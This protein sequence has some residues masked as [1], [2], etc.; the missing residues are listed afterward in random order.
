VTKE[1]SMKAVHRSD[2]PDGA[3]YRPLR[4]EKSLTA[5]VTGAFAAGVLSVLGFLLVVDRARIEDD[6][7][8]ALKMATA[9]D[10]A[11]AVM[12]TQLSAISVRLVGIEAKQEEILEAVK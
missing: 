2:D 10:K 7:E 1:E 3:D 12:T 8:R 6:A 9:N 5:W 4:H 11:I